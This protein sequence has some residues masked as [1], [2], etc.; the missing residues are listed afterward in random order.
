[1]AHSWRLS[2]HDGL[3]HVVPCNKDFSVRDKHSPSLQCN[4][5][6]YI[7]HEGI[8]VHHLRECNGTNAEYNRAWERR[9]LQIA[10]VYEDEGDNYGSCD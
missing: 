9:G 1:M 4:C 5:A 6:P 10:T 7:T 3:T 2:Q 8:V